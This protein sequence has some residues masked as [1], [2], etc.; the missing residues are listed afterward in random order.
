[1]EATGGEKKALM[2]IKDPCSI[3]LSVFPSSAFYSSAHSSSASSIAFILSLFTYIRLRAVF[4]FKIAFSSV[5]AYGDT[6][7]F[8]C[9][10]LVQCLHMSK[11]KQL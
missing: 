6:C 3:S 4:L 2:L 10:L 9:A 5:W 8:G 11:E 7:T 1:M